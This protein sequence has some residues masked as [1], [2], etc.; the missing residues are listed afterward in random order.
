[1]SVGSPWRPKEGDRVPRAGLQTAL[2]CLMW[3]L[4]TEVPSLA[5]QFFLN[6]LSYLDPAVLELFL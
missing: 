1:M 6:A 5:L 4:E 3:V 2:S